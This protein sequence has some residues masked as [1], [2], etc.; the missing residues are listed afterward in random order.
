MTEVDRTPKPCLHPRANH[1]HRTRLAYMFDRC[2]CL[3]CAAANSAYENRR[4]RLRAYGRGTPNGWV[5]AAPVR[6]HVQLLQAA[7]MGWKTVAGAADVA[8]ST[9]CHL[10]Y[11]R[12]RNGRQEPPARRVNPE[13][14]RRLLAVPLPTAEQLPGG[15]VVPATGTQ[16]RLQALAC[17]GWSVGEVARQAD[18]DRQRLDRAIRGQDVVASTVR[19]IAAVYERLWDQR[20][21]PVTH[22]DKVAVSRTINRA[23]RAGW[24]PP[25]AWDDD[26]IDN[27]DVAPQLEHD[28]VDE[29]LVD[30]HV[31]DLVL[32]GQPMR[33][34]GRDL[35][36][37]VERLLAA[38]VDVATIAGRVHTDEATVR[39]TRGR[40]RRLAT[41]D[42]A[43][44]PDRRTR[45]AIAACGTA[46]GYD[47]HRR[48]GETA[49]D[50]CKAAKN[51]SRKRAA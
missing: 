13:A 37:A 11:G 22:A 20:P 14:A 21:A 51:A 6:A 43:A 42:A 5:N 29:D 26:S 45:R 10:L 35:E 23:A 1:Q 46:S 12:R 28:D 33:L 18:L 50:R 49:C 7:G 2:R 40:V 24:A 16:R 25:A 44:G 36:V 47:R 4:A 38:G 3:P 30:E 31:I 17:L 9:L 27:P 19:I 39:R 32:D 41:R 34:T 48:L 8:E 15:V